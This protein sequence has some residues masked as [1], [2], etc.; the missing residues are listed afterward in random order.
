M[1][2]TKF[3]SLLHSKSIYLSQMTSFDDL[4]EGSLSAQSYISNS[5]DACILDVACNL[6]WGGEI[7]ETSEER[8][9]RML[10]IEESKSDID[11]RTFDT[12]FGKFLSEDINEKLYQCKEHI[13]VS[14]WHKSE[15]ESAAM[16]KLFGAE[17]SICIKTSV[18]KIL[19]GNIPKETVVRLDEVKY[20]N[21]SIQNTHTNSLEPFLSKSLA[22]EFEKEVRLIGFNP[23]ENISSPPAQ[24]KE[25]HYNVLHN[26][27]EEII[28]SP[29]S[30]PWFREQII[31][32]CNLY[33]LS[34]PRIVESEL[35]QKPITD[36]Y[37]AMISI[38]KNK[39]PAS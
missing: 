5:N 31:S 27:I 22:Y 23:K 36:I 15:Y 17:N 10:K 26:L 2:L 29:D 9:K 18:S 32:L 7:N 8:N 14:C 3:I 34:N 19:N 30:L 38:E 28:L 11:K 12:P 39:K 1:D 13:Y 37:S 21:H 24:F 6:S 25:I 33:G 16:W 4:L 20:I 35:T